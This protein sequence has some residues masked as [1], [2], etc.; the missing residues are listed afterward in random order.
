M[1]HIVFLYVE[2]GTLVFVSTK[3]QWASQN[4][5]SVSVPSRRPG[6]NVEQ[7]ELSLSHTLHPWR[8]RGRSVLTGH[9]L[10]VYFTDFRPVRIWSRS[11]LGRDKRGKAEQV[12][13]V[14]R[15]HAF[16]TAERLPGNTVH[17]RM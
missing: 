2:E 4:T 6:V 14:V 7:F 12:G 17:S 1:C 8:G 15:R 10:S 11:S 5:R 9:P 16:K 13:R 3:L